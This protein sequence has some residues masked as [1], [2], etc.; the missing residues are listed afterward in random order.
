MN[1]YLITLFESKLITVHNDILF[2]ILR[3]VPLE[4][5]ENLK[6]SCRIKLMKSNCFAFTSLNLRKLAGT[7]NWDFKITVSAKG[8]MYV[9]ITSSVYVK[10]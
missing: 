10:Y 5:H 6:I 1:V 3:N 9:A 7:T 2:L 4:K 8:N